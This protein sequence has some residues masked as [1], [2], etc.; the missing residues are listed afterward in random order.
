MKDKLVRDV[1]FVAFG[2]TTLVL[3]VLVF[4]GFVSFDRPQQTDGDSNGRI[5]KLSDLPLELIPPYLSC[6]Q[7]CIASTPKNMSGCKQDCIDFFDFV[8]QI[9]REVA[10]T[11]QPPKQKQNNGYL[12]QALYAD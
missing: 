3:V 12:N 7:E 10:K 6:V 1:L 2:F 9:T 11:N 8:I 5:E 4:G